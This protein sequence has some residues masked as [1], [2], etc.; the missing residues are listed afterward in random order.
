MNIVFF[1]PPCSGKGTQAVKVSQLFGFSVVD[2]GFLLRT[3]R[4][5]GS[6]K[7]D[8]NKGKLLDDEMVIKVVSE[9][10]LSVSSNGFILDGYPRSL[11]Q[12][13]AMN[14]FHKNYV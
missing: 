1:G 3:S 9:A 13:L 10:L 5:Y 12:V 8:I 6:I 11:N 4:F 7:N 2:A 14:D